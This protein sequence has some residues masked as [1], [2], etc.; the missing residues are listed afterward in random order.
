MHSQTMMHIASNSK[1]FVTMAID[2]LLD[3][4]TLL[5]NGDVLGID[6]KVK[7]VV[8]GWKL[9]DPYMSEHVDLLDLLCESV[10]ARLDRQQTRC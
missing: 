10:V 5:P 4:A 8:P 2:I 3:N 6:T 9:M 1:L 7:D